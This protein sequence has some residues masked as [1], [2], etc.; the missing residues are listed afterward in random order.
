MNKSYADRTRNN[1]DILRRMSHKKRFIVAKSL[2]NIKKN[3]YILD[4]GGGDGDF[5]E[6]LCEL[7]GNDINTFNFEPFMKPKLFSKIKRIDNWDDVT[8]L[9][10][11]KR[12]DIIFCQE[13]LE[14]FNPLRQEDALK[15]MASV[16]DSDGRLIIS[17][18]V[19]IGPVALVKNIGRWKYRKYNPSIYNFRN[20]F[21]S[22]FGIKINEERL[23]NDFLSHMGFYFNDLKKIINKDFIIEKTSASPMFWAP[24]IF[25]SQV[26]FVCRLKA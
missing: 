17:V 10:K 16:M 11:E 26:F 13:V 24:K 1:N 5:L 21:K 12:F 7:Y 4:F 20:L 8:S 3:S 14:H 6:K 18:P 9:S 22:F 15:K 2:V 19:E 23:K 25:N